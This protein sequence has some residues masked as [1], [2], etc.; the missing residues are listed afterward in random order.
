MNPRATHQGT[1]RE[2]T[3]VVVRDRVSEPFRSP[4]TAVIS[5]TSDRPDI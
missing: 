4:F 3:A 2:G 5:S 1:E